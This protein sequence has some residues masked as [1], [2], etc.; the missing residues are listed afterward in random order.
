MSTSQIDTMANVC[1]GRRRP[2][3]GRSP[4]GNATFRAGDL[5]LTIFEKPKRSGRW[6]YSLLDQ[7][8]G[9]S[10]LR[11]AREPAPTWGEAYTAGCDAAGW[12]G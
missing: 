4:K 5:L 2:R 9:R 11:F 3:M 6:W 12:P 8:G 10:R 7:S 1:L